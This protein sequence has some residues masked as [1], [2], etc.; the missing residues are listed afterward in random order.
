MAPTPRT[1]TMPSGS[2][3]RLPRATLPKGA[4]DLA[5]PVHAPDA[6][7]VTMPQAGSTARPVEQSADHPAAPQGC[8]EPGLLQW[9]CL[10]RPQRPWVQ[11]GCSVEGNVARVHSPE[12]CEQQGSCLAS[13]CT[14]IMSTSA[15]HP[16]PKSSSCCACLQGHAPPPPLRRPIQPTA[17]LLLSSTPPW[18]PQGGTWP[19]QPASH[20]AL[21]GR[22]IPRG[23]TG[24]PRT[25]TPM[26]LTL[27]EGGTQVIRCPA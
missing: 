1:G 20:S 25:S 22:Q 19:P 14:R 15:P 27:R 24:P 4:L 7:H 11:P 26:E 18:L 21:G 17:E 6:L 5:W 13:P 8:H 2:G 3:P 9:D 10:R 16:H 12:R 23:V